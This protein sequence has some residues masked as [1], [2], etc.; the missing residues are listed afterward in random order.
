MRAMAVNGPPIDCVGTGRERGRAHGEHL[1]ERIGEAIERWRGDAARRSGQSAADYA[2][3]FLADTDFLPAIQ[4]HTPDLLEE[5]RGIAEGA[6]VPFEAVLVRNLMDEEWW[7]ALRRGHMAACSTIAVAGDDGRP[8]LLAQ[9][10]DLPAAMDSEQT[11]L[12]IAP[13]GAPPQLVLSAAGMI[14]LTGASA[15][16]LGMCVNAL[17]MLGHSA[18]GLPVA[19][20]MRGALVQPD[21]EAAAAFLRAVPHASGQHYA[22][23]SPDRVVGYECSAAGAVRS[24]AGPR[25]WH[26][27]H[28]LRSTDLDDRVPPDPA[29]AGHSGTR[30][31]LL[32]RE[33]PRVRS[34][35]DCQRLL[36]DRS[37]PL[38]VTGPNWITFGS[39]AIEVTAAGAR[40]SHTTGPPDR[41]PWSAPVT[42]A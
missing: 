2:A 13:P 14:G 22:L 16:G 32:E 34:L 19:F 18:A 20:V 21:L 6:E 9:N 7:Y 28:P 41:T 42:V 29:A 11:M 10:M 37:A 17:T 36:A 15:S 26:T 24:A 35:E 4:R 8:S 12:R 1:R 39:I 3:G 38:C 5:V 27:N 33:L 40:I 23:A 30:G 31:R 25:L